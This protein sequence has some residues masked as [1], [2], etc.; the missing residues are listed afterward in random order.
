MTHIIHNKIIDKDSKLKI[1]HFKK[2]QN[3]KKLN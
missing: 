2:N 3:K 1:R